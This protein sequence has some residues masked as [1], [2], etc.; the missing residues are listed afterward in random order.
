[1]VLNRRRFM[2]GGWPHPHAPAWEGDRRDLPCD[3]ILQLHPARAETAFTAI[4]AG[5]GIT[6]TQRDSGRLRLSLSG[7]AATDVALTLERMTRIP[8]V[9]SATIASLAPQPAQGRPA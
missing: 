5:D 3:V 4:L 1:M 7:T 8:G 9:L 6:I 2:T